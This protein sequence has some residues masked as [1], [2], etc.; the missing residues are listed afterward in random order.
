[1]LTLPGHVVISDRG[2]WRGFGGSI[3]V[4]DQADHAADVA[5]AFSPSAER[6]GAGKLRVARAEL[7]VRM[8][9]EETEQGEMT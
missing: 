2:P 4:Y 9:D 3:V 7:R 8:D 5:R 1:M 6:L